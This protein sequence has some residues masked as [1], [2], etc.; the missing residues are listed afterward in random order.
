MQ[1]RSGLNPVR[2]Y[3]EHERV[4]DVQRIMIVETNLQPPAH[5]A[6]SPDPHSIWSIDLNDADK[7]V[8]Y[9][10]GFELTDG[11]KFSTNDGHRL[12]DFPLCMK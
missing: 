11:T 12:F 8:I 9:T 1:V 2:V 7:F 3:L 5:T 4:D 6:Q 10:V